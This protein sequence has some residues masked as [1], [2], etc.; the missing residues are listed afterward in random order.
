MIIH[1]QNKT[2]QKLILSLEMGKGLK[3]DGTQNSQN[4]KVIYYPYTQTLKSIFTQNMKA[5]DVLTPE[6]LIQKP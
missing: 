4:E 3:I 1:Y 5:F 2:K 6:E